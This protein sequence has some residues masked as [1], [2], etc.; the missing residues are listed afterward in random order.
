MVTTENRARAELYRRATEEWEVLKKTH[1]EAWAKYRVI[2]EAMVDARGEIMHRHELNKPAGPGYQKD[3]M[4]WLVRHKLDDMHKTT[5]SHLCELIDHIDEVDQM[6]TGWSLQQR[7]E[8]NAP[9][10]V[11]RKWQAWKRKQGRT[12]ERQR[13][14]LN[15]ARQTSDELAIALERIEEL[16]QEL[17]S[18]KAPDTA[19]VRP[20]DAASIGGALTTLLSFGRF[21]LKDLGDVKPNP[22]D[23]IELVEVLKGIAAELKAKKSKPTATKKPDA[24]AT[25]KPVTKEP[26]KSATKKSEEPAKRAKLTKLKWTAGQHCAYPMGQGHHSQQ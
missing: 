13:K 25:P 22:T 17:Q 10:T 11:H 8:W 20:V 18:A 21:G 2:G 9:N 1:R 14:K 24:T 4:S 7:M 23:V 16:K 5:R 12:S 19:S 26:T 6:M 15:T 3:I